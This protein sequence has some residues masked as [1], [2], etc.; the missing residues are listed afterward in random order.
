M[1]LCQIPSFVAPTNSDGPRSNFRQP[2]GDSDP[3]PK[4]ALS[5]RNQ[6]ESKSLGA[7]QTWS[8]GTELAA[9]SLVTSAQ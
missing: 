4:E 5:P 7:I 9:R 1:A 2:S 8:K 3:E 6:L